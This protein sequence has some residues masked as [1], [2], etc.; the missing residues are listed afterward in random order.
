MTESLS[1][2]VESQRQQFLS[3]AS[4]EVNFD[5]EAQFA[6][7]LFDANDYLKNVALQN[8]PSVIAAINNVAAIGISLNPALKLAYLVPRKI[9]KVVSVCLDISYMGLLHT[10][11]T[12]GAILWGQAEI[13][14]ANDTFTL[15][16]IDQ[17]PEHHFNPFATDRGEIVGCYV[18]VKTC[19]G[20]Y[21]TH[22]MPISEIY[23]IRDRSE[24]WKNRVAKEKKGEWV[25]QSPWASDEK[26][27]IKKTVI[28]QASKYW[29]RREK[30]DGAV[31]YL[32]QPENEGIRF[33]KDVTP[34]HGSVVGDTLSAQS[35]EEQ[36]RAQ[37]VSTN[38]M[39]MLDEGMEWGAYDKYK[40]ETDS[41]SDF[42]ESVWCILGKNKIKINGKEILYRSVLT[43][44]RKAEENGERPE[45][46]D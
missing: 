3:V 15:R 10:A 42:K 20:D 46:G 6:M 23:A 9:N 29:P 41:D 18:V 22:S 36:E 28:K 25:P 14:H 38:I 34:A 24:S 8:K 37:Q 40:E 11:Q 12:S 5:K 4:K 13:V 45:G 33:E 16:N 32:N 21:L 19:D 7:Q 27:M 44:L 2:I 17:A 1:T 35:I 26:E 43:K 31:H 39:E 30:L